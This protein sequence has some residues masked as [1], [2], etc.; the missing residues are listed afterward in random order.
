[1]TTR[2]DLVRNLPAFA[3]LANLQ[4]QAQANPSAGQ[5]SKPDPAKVAAGTKI[6]TDNHIFSH[7]LPIKTSKTGSSQAVVQGVLPTGEGIEMHN[8]TLN[9]GMAPHPPHQHMH[10]E[11]L[12]IRE[13]N[14]EWLIDGKWQPAQAGDILFASSMK[15]HGLKNVGTTTASY[16]VMAVGPNLK[17]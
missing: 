15:L 1:M 10:S 4:L 13:G 11:W 17:G 9:P 16:F 14:M 6:F 8:T 5:E 3:L 2:R 12:F 7:D